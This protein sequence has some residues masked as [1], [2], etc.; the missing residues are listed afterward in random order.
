MFCHQ[1]AQNICDHKMQM[2][3]AMRLTVLSRLS[4]ISTSPEGYFGITRFP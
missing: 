4:S 1:S 2:S 3:S